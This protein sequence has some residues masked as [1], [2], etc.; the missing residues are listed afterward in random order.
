MKLMFQYKKIKTNLGMTH[1]TSIQSHPESNLKYNRGMTYVELIVVLTIFS[2]MTSLVIFS[3]AEFQAKV[4][5]KNLAS[6]IALK[7][8][9]AQKSS[10]YGTLPGAAQYALLPP[11]W[12]PSYGVYI[13]KSADD[14]SFIYFTDI[15]Q[16]S[17]LENPTCS[18]VSECL[19]KITITKGNII[20]ELNVFYRGEIPQVPHS[21]DDL[22]ITFRRPNT[23]AVVRSSQI[24]TPPPF[25]ISHVEITIVS[26][27]APTATIQ[28]YSS[29]RV[30]IN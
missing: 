8:V 5:I 30:Q 28:L 20:S 18:G 11:N 3:H 17:Y 12:K 26:P 24:T 15:D 7:I 25:P 21:L 23:S 6:D 10:I 1:S 9:Q 2:V 29:G 13:D 19:E 14:K 4:D 16:N 22:T 27:K